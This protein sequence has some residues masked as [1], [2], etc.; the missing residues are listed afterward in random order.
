[1]LIHPPQPLLF[2]EIE[3]V[4]VPALIDTGSMKSIISSEIFQRISA[5]CAST[6][7][8]SPALHADSRQ[9]VAITGQ[10]LTSSGSAIVSLS[11]PQSDFMYSIE[12]LVCDNLLPPLQCVLGWDFLTFYSLQLAVFEGS[13]CLVG[14]HGCTSLTPWSPAVAHP[15]PPPLQ[16]G[17]PVFVQ[18]SDYG[19]AYVTVPSD[20]CLPSRSECIVQAR[21]PKSYAG[22][23]GMVCNLNE[24]SEL[25]CFT[26]YSIGLANDQNIPV[27]VLN[28]S[29]ADIQF[30]AGQK[31]A[32]FWPVIESISPTS[33][34]QSTCAGVLDKCQ[35]QAQTL[36]ELQSALSPT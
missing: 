22:M 3:G 12:F 18:S 25:S 14:P 28:T 13:Y 11:F 21:V 16:N 19:P 9:C 20:I 29:L 10:P 33:P 30:H 34:M 1:M 17:L 35:I 2:C 27:R 5:H 24:G 23:L 6:H 36:A 31:T 26:A 4:Q 32:R 7:K 8:T 15:Q